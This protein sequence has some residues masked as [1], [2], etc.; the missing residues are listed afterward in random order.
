MVAYLLIRIVGPRSY[1]FRNY[2]D[3]KKQEVY[4]FYVW[5]F[6]LEMFYN[7]EQMLF[8]RYLER[9]WYGKYITSSK[10]K[11]H[12]LNNIYLKSKIN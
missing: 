11:R 5:F 8:D 2:T 7:K 4:S 10:E 12:T 6:M 1:P 9:N 3:D